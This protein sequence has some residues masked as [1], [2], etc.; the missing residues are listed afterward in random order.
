MGSPPLKKNQEPGDNTAVPQRLRQTK[1]PDMTRE[2]EA[3]VC[4]SSKGRSR[5]PQVQT[6]SNTRQPKPAANSEA[7]ALPGA[8]W[9]ALRASAVA[10]GSPRQGNVASRCPHR[11]V[12]L[13]DGISNWVAGCK[14]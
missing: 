8:P 3:V 12:A 11:R 2:T 4:R 13:L 10:R 5:G 6:M 7:S 1:L 9:R 14:A